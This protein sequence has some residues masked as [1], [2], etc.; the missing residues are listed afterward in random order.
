MYPNGDMYE[1]HWKK[2][3]EHGTGRKV[4]KGGE[5]CVAMVTKRPCL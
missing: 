3:K 1:G 5:F 2:N 4:I